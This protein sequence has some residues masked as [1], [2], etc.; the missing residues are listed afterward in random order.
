MPSRPD[1]YLAVDL[2]PRGIRVNTL[3]PGPI[4]TISARGVKGLLDMIEHVN[5]RSPLKREYGQEEVA[6]SAV[7]LASDLSRGVT[8]QV[9]YIDNG[10]NIVGT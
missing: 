7:Y 9:I 10:Y 3:S 1:R 8:G 6:G 4:N 2:G 5:M